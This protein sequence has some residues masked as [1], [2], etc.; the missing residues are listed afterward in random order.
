MTFDD[1]LE[2]ILGDLTP[3]ANTVHFDEIHELLVLLL[4]P[5]LLDPHIVALLGLPVPPDALG[6][7]RGGPTV[8]SCSRVLTSFSD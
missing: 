6:S 3:L 7:D 8:T 1:G 5:D 2:H 4:R